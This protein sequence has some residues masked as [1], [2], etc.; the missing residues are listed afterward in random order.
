MTEM[1]LAF[2]FG[3]HR[4]SSTTSFFS[5]VSVF[6]S[7]P[8]F[9][10]GEKKADASNAEIA[11]DHVGILGNRHPMNRVAFHCVVQRLVLNDCAGTQGS[12]T[13]WHLR[14]QMPHSKIQYGGKA[15]PGQIGNQ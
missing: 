7:K 3:S 5:W 9:A 11:F 15:D 13:G 8:V 10:C 12:Y 6:I 1:S 4:N 2:T 14:V